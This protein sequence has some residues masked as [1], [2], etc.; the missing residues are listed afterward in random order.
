MQDERQYSDRVKLI[1]KKTGKFSANSVVCILGMHRSGTSCLAGCLEEQGLHLG[2]VVNSAPFNLR[3]NKENITLRAINDDVLSFSGG[4]W[5]KPP[6]HL[7]WDDALRQRRDNHISKYSTFKIWGFK[8]PRTI[9]TLPFWLEANLN[10]KFVGTFRH[11]LSVSQSLKRRRG[12]KPILPPVKLWQ[13]YNLKLLEYATKFRFPLV[14]FDRPAKAYIRDLRKVVHILGLNN[15]SDAPF[16]FFDECLK[17]NN[18]LAAEYEH[19][20][21][22][23]MSIYNSLL[24]LAVSGS[25][26]DSHPS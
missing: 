23:S 3:G 7:V 20:D 14:C 19:M 12:L 5:D 10:I 21:A 25:A 22:E 13:H 24:T 18:L 4:T 16:Q 2:E 11:P 26:S 1:Y 8:D 17:N 9:L 6:E 15:A